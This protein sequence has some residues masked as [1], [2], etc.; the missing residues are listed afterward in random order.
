MGVAQ[1]ELQSKKDLA[2]GRDPECMHTV[3]GRK[4]S[5]TLPLLTVLPILFPAAN[6]QDS[7]GDTV[8][9]G[10]LPGHRAGTAE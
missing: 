2:T 3:V 8:G 7:L 1:E 9:R 6:R 4:V 5:Q 10:Q